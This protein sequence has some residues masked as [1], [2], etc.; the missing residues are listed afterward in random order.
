MEDSNLWPELK[1]WLIAEG[2]DPISV[3]KSK[4]RTNDVRQMLFVRRYPEPVPMPLDR[5]CLKVSDA[6]YLTLMGLKDPDERELENLYHVTTLLVLLLLE[7]G[8]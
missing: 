8:N 1:T 2:S 7:K 4:V 5:A 6:V 3:L